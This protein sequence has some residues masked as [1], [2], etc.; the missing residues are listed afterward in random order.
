MKLGPEVMG[1]ADLARDELVHL[2]EGDAKESVEGVVEF[3]FA[4]QSKI[5]K[6]REKLK[7]E[8]VN[9]K[10]PGLDDSRNS[11]P[12]QISKATNYKRFS[13][14]KACSRVKTEDV[15]EQSY[16]SISKSSKGQS[17]QLHYKIL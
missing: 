8:L 9:E 15:A 11:Q 12:S 10:E 3:I 14:R 2:A 6:E 13:V 16:T 7:G 5:Q 1:K 4:A 17:S